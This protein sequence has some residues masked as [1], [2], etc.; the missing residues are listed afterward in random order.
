MVPIE[1]WWGRFRLENKVRLIGFV[2]PDEHDGKEQ[3]TGSNIRFD[4]NT[5]YI[6]FLDKNHQFYEVEKS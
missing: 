6:V 1:A 5:F 4:K 3:K 2:L